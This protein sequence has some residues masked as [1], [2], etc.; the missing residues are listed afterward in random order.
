MP[1]LRKL[2]F[3]LII[4]NNS[5]APN[6]KVWTKSGLVAI[7]TLFALDGTGLAKQTP[8]EVWS[9]NERTQQNELKTVEHVFINED[10]YI[11][12]LE[13]FDPAARRN[14]TTTTTP[15][16]PFYV[17]SKEK[18]PWTG[19]GELEVDDEIRKADGNVGIV[20][21]VR[22]KLEKTRQSSCATCRSAQDV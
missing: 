16:H 12:T 22:T 20:L 8:D 5:F 3:I 4:C 21:F 9:Y 10:D 18:E 19:A 17:S 13:L 2:V 7:A 1:I 14:E 15:E 6:A 11:T